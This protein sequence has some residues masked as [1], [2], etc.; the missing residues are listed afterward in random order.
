MRKAALA[1][2]IAAI[3]SA[4]LDSVFAGFDANRDGGIDRAELF[5]DFRLDQRPFAEI[6]ADPA[7]VDWQR[8]AGRFGETGRL[9]LP[10]LLN[11][12]R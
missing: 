6:V 5:A 2:A 9:F 1:I 4:G 11:A 12:G 8:F 10:L 7:A 3:D